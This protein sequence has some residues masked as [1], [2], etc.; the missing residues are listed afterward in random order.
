MT[1]RERSAWR[2]LV[3]VQLVAVAAV[4]VAAVAVWL[5][6]SCAC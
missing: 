1:P 3:G 2:L 4:G 5:L 6:R